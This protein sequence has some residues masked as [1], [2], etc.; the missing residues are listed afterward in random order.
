MT[1]LFDEHA[2]MVEAFTP[3]EVEQ[4]LNEARE[5]AIEETNKLRQEEVDDLSLQ[6]E[7]KD[8]ELEQAKQELEV[9]KSKDKNLAGQGR[10]IRDK[11]KKIDELE[12]NYKKLEEKLDQRINDVEVKSREKMVNS[13]INELSG[14]DKDMT[15]KIKFYFDSFKGEP[16]DDNEIQ[17]RI[18]NAYVLATGA[19]PTSPLSGAVLSSSGGMPVINPSGEKLSDAGKAAARDLGITDQE[20]KKYKLI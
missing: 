17:Q 20:L 4:K 9:E 19:K 7:S 11:E 15:N 16:A 8:R 3:E 6:I 10:I 13:M 2:Q 14:N 1:Q 18:Q 5:M 12:I